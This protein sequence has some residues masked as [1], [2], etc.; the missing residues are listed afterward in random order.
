MGVLLSLV[1]PKYDRH[2]D[3]RREDGNAGCDQRGA[4]PRIRAARI[5][6]ILID[7]KQKVASL[8]FMCRRALPSHGSKRSPKNARA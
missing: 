8:T 3:A 7:P 1:V 5:A 6:Q 4:G 2:L